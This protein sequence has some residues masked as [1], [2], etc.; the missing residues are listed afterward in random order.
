MHTMDVRKQMCAFEVSRRNQGVPVRGTTF[1]LRSGED[2]V[3]YKT[4]YISAGRSWTA[5]DNP[6]SKSMD[7]TANWTSLDESGHCAEC[8]KT[9]GCEFDSCPTCPLNPEF[10]RIAAPWSQHHVC[11]LTPI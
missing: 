2:R 8:S 4:D 6:M 7:S 3:D 11:S 5:L 9:A 10:M 1:S